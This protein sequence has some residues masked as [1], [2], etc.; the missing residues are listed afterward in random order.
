MYTSSINNNSNHCNSVNRGAVPAT[1]RPATI[2]TQPV[3]AQQNNHLLH[4]QNRR[5]S[6]SNHL[7][8]SQILAR[9]A[10]AIAAQPHVLSSTHL[11]HGQ[12]LL[13]VAQPSCFQQPP[14]PVQPITT[15]AAASRIAQQLA[16]WQQQ[17]YM[18]NL[19]IKTATV[20]AS[21]RPFAARP[22]C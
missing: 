7:L 9:S 12:L 2:A 19:T 1:H 13:I 20:A 16:S 17:P 10:A 18:P 14:V 6:S 4:S 3:F 22:L 11:P 5:S 21:A 8:P 15:H